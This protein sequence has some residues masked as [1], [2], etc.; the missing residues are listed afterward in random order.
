MRQVEYIVLMV[1]AGLLLTFQVFYCASFAE[2][3]LSDIENHWCESYVKTLLEENIVSGYPDGSYQPSG[4]ITN[5]EFLSLVLKS[6]GQQPGSPARD[7]SWDAPVIRKALDL[8]LVKSSEPMINGRD[9][10]T[11]EQS[12][13]IL[14][15][16]LQQTENLEDYYGQYDIALES[17]TNDYEEISSDYLPGV[18]MMFQQGIMNGSEKN[19]DK[20]YDDRYLN[21]KG[22]L[23]RAEMSVLI[24][25]LIDSS[26]RLT[27]DE[28]NQ[29]LQSKPVVRFLPKASEKSVAMDFKDGMP[30]I[31]RNDVISELSNTTYNFE[32]SFWGD[33]K[34]WDELVNSEWFFDYTLEQKIE[35]SLDQHESSVKV[36]E[37]AFNVSYKDDLAKYEKDLKYYMPYMTVA[38]EFVEGWLTFVKKDQATIKGIVVS[39]KSLYYSDSSSF[40]R[41]KMRLYFKVESSKDEYRMFKE[42]FQFKKGSIL[43]K[44]GQWY[45]VDMEIATSMV[46]GE[47]RLFQT[48]EANENTFAREWYLSDY[49]PVNPR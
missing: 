45:Q 16:A 17:M 9:Y 24:S 47:G 49:I 40:N 1:V 34:K 15:R 26:L 3:T 33:T 37:R 12:A 35:K 13:L 43:L 20:Y 28:I 22:T 31:N 10:I 6:I 44:T 18:A 30:N 36:I 11:R 25:K 2:T 32:T 14:Y 27:V 7:E 48:W 38:V 42:L 4:Q 5:G 23:T 8:C 46:A 39:D 41:T 21:P 19:R 29:K